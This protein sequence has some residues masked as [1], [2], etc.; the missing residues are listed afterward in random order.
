MSCRL[1]LGACV[2]LMSFVSTGVTAQQ[3]QRVDAHMHTTAANRIRGEVPICVGT[4]DPELGGVLPFQ[5]DDPRWERCSRI[6]TSV[7]TREELMARTLELYEHYNVVAAVGSDVTPE[8]SVDWQRQVPYVLIPGWG[9]TPGVVPVDS[10]RSL[11]ESGSVAFLGEFSFQYQ[12]ISPGDSVVAPYLAL[13]EE[14]DVPVGAHM[15]PGFPG[16]AVRASRN[17]RGRYGD[18][19]LWDEPLAQ[20]PNLRVVIQH[21]GWPWLD[22][23]LSLLFTFPNVYVDVGQV[24]WLLPRAEFHRYL[25]AL[26][27]A[28]FERRIMWGSD[29]FLWPDAIGISI[30][31]LESA[32]FLSEAAKQAI[33]YENA[34][35]FYRLEALLGR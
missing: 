23:T 16:G 7:G 18:P 29:G 15:G 30:E 6:L 32:P 24:A 2:V 4:L 3:R 28:G 21:A 17:Y 10:V 1:A 27:E 31:A 14:L 26:V 8:A 5:A 19:L 12:G 22:S 11:L 35:R 13:A 9:F 33:F 34:V 25:R 20:H